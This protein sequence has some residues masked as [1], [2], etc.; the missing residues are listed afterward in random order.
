MNVL[1]ALAKMTREAYRLQKR[2]ACESA[3]L[4][5]LHEKYTETVRV[6]TER[7]DLVKSLEAK[8]FAAEEKQVPPPFYAMA[9][10]LVK[11]LGYSFDHEHGWTRPPVAPTPELPLPMFKAAVDKLNALG[12]AWSVPDQR[13]FDPIPLPSSAAPVQPTTIGRP[14]GLGWRDALKAAPPRNMAQFIEAVLFNG[15]EFGGPAGLIDW[16]E[17][18]VGVAWWRFR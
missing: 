11:S 3:N 9:E 10:K 17:S 6:A 5:S 13:W 1:K 16:N 14:E 8:L 4:D 2:L 7:Y 15:T 12:H 18:S